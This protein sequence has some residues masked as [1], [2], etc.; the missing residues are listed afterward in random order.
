MDILI[1]ALR[2][3]FAPLGFWGILLLTICVLIL[4]VF[5]AFIGDY[6]KLKN[7][8][9][10]ANHNAKLAK[11][12]ATKEKVEVQLGVKAELVLKHTDRKE[13]WLEI[14]IINTGEITAFIKRIAA[15]LEI[16]THKIV[17]TDISF[18]PDVS[19]LNPKKQTT[20]ELKPHGAEYVCNLVIKRNYRFQI[21]EK[22]GVNYSKGYVELTTGKK[23]EFEFQ[24][25]S[26]KTWDAVA[27]P[28]FFGE[29]SGK[30][31]HKCSGCGSVF[32]MRNPALIA[33][34]GKKPYVTCP[35]CKH[36]DAL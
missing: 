32:F 10:L 1:T 15:L 14:T 4:S 12:L 7:A 33:V 35:H 18:T 8:I 31:P 20:I 36:V 2:D 17:G 24:L 9:T 34:D 21:H 30:L 27:Q 26:E 13:V 25:L 28:E 3:Y 22:G 19:E 6:F 11:E 23:F 5:V 29:F 16:D